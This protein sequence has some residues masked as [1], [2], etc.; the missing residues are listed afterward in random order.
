MSETEM[1]AHA[2]F[3]RRKKSLRQRSTSIIIALTVEAL[4][5][6]GLI[7][8]GG[9]VP[10]KHQQ[11]AP[12]SVNSWSLTHDSPKPAATHQST[13]APKAEPAKPPPPRQRVLPPQIPPPLS[14]RAPSPVVELSKEDYAA[15]DIGK[16][17]SSSADSSNATGKGA[18]P[19]YGPGEGPGGARLISADWYEEPSQGAL[20]YYLPKGLPPDSWAMIACQTAPHYHVENCM[21]LSESPPGSG[22]GKA[23]RQAS[24]QFLVRPPMLNGKPMI[25]T[26]VKIRFNWITRNADK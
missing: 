14:P 6:F 20:A 22:L 12:L 17:K 10:S 24:W 15:S 4:I 2:G 16:L 8:L 23:M 3:T 13:Q 25:G 7:R 21:S 9:W 1:A 26:W 11:S 19:S 5:F 18:G